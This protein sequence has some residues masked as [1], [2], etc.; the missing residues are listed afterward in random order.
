MCELRYVGVLLCLSAVVGLSACGGGGSSGS[1]PPN[2][3]YVS[4]R[5]GSDTN[6]GDQS[7]PLKSV[8]AAGQLALT[9]YKIIVGSGTYKDGVTPPAQGA[10]PHGVQ[11]IADVSGTLTNDPPGPVVIDASQSAVQAGFKMNS[12]AGTLIDGF[13]ITGAADAGI[14]LKSGSDNF[15]IQNCIIHDNSGDGIRVQDSGHVLVFN[16]LVYNSGADGIGIGGNGVPPAPSGSSNA[17]IVNNTIFGSQSYGILIGTTNVAS[18]GAFVRNN[19]LQTNALSSSIDANIK[20]TSTATARSEVN[21]QGDFNLVY[22]PDTY[23]GPQ[24]IQGAND[25]NADALLVNPKSINGLYLQ[26]K[27]PAIDHGGSLN[28]LMTVG[29][30]GRP[31]LLS[32]FLAGRT[33][34]GSTADTGTIDMGYHYPL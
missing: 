10:A 16:N 34:T 11:Y 29:A 24:G 32:N 4:V 6:L 22:A 9:G 33:T 21:Y 3:L 18:P 5:T 13:T 14:V 25:I 8:A 17:T 30:N 19:L 23:F 20:V 26:G 2:P 27:S 1:R 12:S 7:H 28:N 15:T 31:I